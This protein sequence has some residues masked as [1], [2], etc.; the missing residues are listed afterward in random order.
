MFQVDLTRDL[1]ELISPAAVGGVSVSISKG[2]NEV[3]VE[4]KLTSRDLS[5]WIYAD[6]A[7]I[8][9]KGIDIRFE[10]ADHH[11]PSMLAKAFLKKVSETIPSGDTQ[12]SD[13]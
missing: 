8:P 7:S 1:I 11:E 5:F 9:G 13:S 10:V 2:P 6:E 3:I 12:R 4:A